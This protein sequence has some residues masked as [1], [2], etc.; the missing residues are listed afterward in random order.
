M[1]V[2]P[3]SC[4]TC[5]NGDR[6]GL[7]LQGIGWLFLE[8]ERVTYLL[9]AKKEFPLLFPFPHWNQIH[10]YHCPQAT[11]CP[12]K[13]AKQHASQWQMLASRRRVL[14]SQLCWPSSPQQASRL[15]W[16]RSPKV[17]E[18]LVLIGTR[19]CDEGMRYELNCDMLREM[20]EGDQLCCRHRMK[21]C[22]LQELVL[23]VDWRQTRMA[24][25]IHRREFLLVQQL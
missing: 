5:F 11:L 18:L 2:P 20:V 17:I 1:G 12:K 3:A 19:W 14:L 8:E 4:I 13:T 6:R 15:Q 25:P 21:A 16:P 7:I 24:Y 23:L 9:S 22:Q 10:C